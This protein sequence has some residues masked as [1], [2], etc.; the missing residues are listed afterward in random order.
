MK[1]LVIL[2]PGAGYGLDCPLLYY[3]DFL[4]ETK[5][6]ERLHMKYQDILSRVDISVEDKI[7]MLRQ[8]TWEQVKDVDFAQYQEVVFLSKSVGAIEAGI[9]AEKL[10]IAVK[11]IF[12][13]PVEDAVVY[14]RNTSMVIIGEN[15]KAYSLYRK[16]CEEEG[17]NVLCVEHADHSLEIS[18]DPYASIHALGRVINFIE[19]GIHDA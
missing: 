16:Q 18:N 13:T 17:A 7:E 14:L 19:M 8:Y 4:F 12:L 11:Q 6:Y 15:D 5:G 9:I 2:F 10:N 3:A 1:K